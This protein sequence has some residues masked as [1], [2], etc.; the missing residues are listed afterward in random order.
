M[1]NLKQSSLVLCLS[2]LYLYLFIL[3]VIKAASGAV[4]VDFTQ[5]RGET[6]RLMFGTVDNDNLIPS[7]NAGQFLMD[8]VAEYVYTTSLFL[9]YFNFFDSLSSV[10]GGIIPLFRFWVYFKMIYS[11]LINVLQHEYGINKS[12]GFN[13]HNE[14]GWSQFCRPLE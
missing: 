9:L 11:K 4:E 14:V 13:K 2:F 1:G 3:P 5:V 7:D 6:T 10:S 8:R 12:C